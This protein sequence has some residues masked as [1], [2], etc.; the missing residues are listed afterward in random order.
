MTNSQSL[1]RMKKTLL[2]ATA[3][4]GCLWREARAMEEESKED[5]SSPYYSATNIRTEL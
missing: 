5:S 1:L 3:L 2:L 4:C